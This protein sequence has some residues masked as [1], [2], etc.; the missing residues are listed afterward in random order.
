MS[1]VCLSAPRSI[2]LS[3]CLLAG[4]SIGPSVGWLVCLSAVGWLVGLSVRLSV[5]SAFAMTHTICL[6]PH[7]N[8]HD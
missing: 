1:A 6:I 7:L 4:W 8:Y 3:F 5:F 2:C